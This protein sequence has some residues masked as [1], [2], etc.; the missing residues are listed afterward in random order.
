MQRVSLPN[1]G[2]YPLRT[3][4]FA[5]VIYGLATVLHGSGF[6][7]VFVAGLLVSGARFPHKAEIE[8]FHISLASIAEI[9]VFVT[10][11]LTVDLTELFQAGVWL[12]GLVLAL[13]L[14]FV[15]RPIAVGALLLPAR[16]RLGERLFVIWGGLKGAVPILLAA[17]AV[18]AEVQEASRIYGIVFL[19]VAFSVIV[20]GTTIPYVAAKLG[21]PMRTLEP[22]TW[23]STPRD[24]EENT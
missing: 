18:L 8:H 11:G 13:V 17:F 22:E 23:S 19:V 1:A 20:Q 21:V 2:L 14:G 12:D 16:L 3:L 7:A 9:V 6:L 15:A 4:A 5:G 10:L 24:R